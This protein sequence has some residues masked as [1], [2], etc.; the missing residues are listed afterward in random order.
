MNAEDSRLQERL[1]RLEAGDALADC[2]VGLPPEQ[3][4]LLALAWAL[5]QVSVPGQPEDR[6]AAQ[7]RTL[8]HQAQERKVMEHP[9]ETAPES[10]GNRNWPGWLIPAGLGAAALSAILFIGLAILVVAGLFLF[11][12]G[13]ADKDTTPSRTV[14]LLAPNQP[15]SA[16]GLGPDSVVVPGADRLVLTGLQGLVEV[17]NEAGQ[18][19][20]AQSGQELAGGQRLRTG[21]LSRVTLAFYDGSSA[22]LEADTEVS[23]DALDA[24]RDGPRQVVLTQVS[25]RTRHDVAHS[26]VA[27]SQ[28]VVNTPYGTGEAKGTSFTVL[29]TGIFARFNTDEGTVA[30]TNLSVTVLVVAGQSSTVY[31]GEA[32]QEPVFRIIGEGEVGL[33]GDTWG[34]SGRSFLTN[35]TTQIIGNPQI[36]DWVRVEAR[37]LP[38]GTRF[39]DRIELLRRAPENGFEITGEVESQEAQ[40][41][42]IGGQPVSVDGNTA[43]QVGIAPGDVVVASGVVLGDGTLLAETIR[44]YGDEPAFPFEFLGVVEDQSGPWVISAIEI[45]TDDRT[46]INGEIAVGSVVKVEGW[47][48]EDG[49]WLAD[50][51]KLSEVDDLKFE[52][53]GLVESLDPWL[54]SGI[55]IATADWTEI[56]GEIAVG[57]RVQ[58]EGTVQVD[59][60]WLAG[61][62]RLIPEDALDEGQAAFRFVLIG[63]V[64]SIDPW[65]VSEVAF[66]VDENTLIGDGIEI[67]SRVYVSGLAQ[68]DDTLLAEVIARLDL[69]DEVGCLTYVTVVSSVE[70][71]ALTLYTGQLIPLTGETEID[72]ELAAGAVILLATCT[73]EDNTITVVVIVVIAYLDEVP[74]PPYTGG[75]DGGTGDEGGSGDLG[76]VVCHIPPGNP[77]NRHTIIVGPG[78]V[79]A[80]LGHGDTPGPC[81]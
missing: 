33:T 40:V 20:P 54:V 35:S 22:T 55:E 16:G 21:A 68:E 69:Q 30:V 23:V 62:I 13:R 67:G 43:V 70:E 64:E 38:D 31:E 14:E 56:I 46:E 15:V 71:D 26:D 2:Q 29:V 76:T 53:V 77:D 79:G 41:W 61:E 58:V 49:T 10:G 6:T 8:M 24:R 9:T 39:A 72:G 74:E 1:E 63:E 66:T 32:P 60:T 48:L 3:A 28:Y 25:G 12:G 80:H 7:R 52:F 78:A 65:L 81:P 19:Q 37:V 44:L 75:E 27:G 42:A 17:Q 45:T 57:D 34:I 36:G 47:I 18:W 4:E 11:R 73:D 59:G 50:E 51:I 5:R